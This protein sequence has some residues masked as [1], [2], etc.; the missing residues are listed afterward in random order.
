MQGVGGGGFE[1]DLGKSVDLEAFSDERLSG[2]AEGKP[3]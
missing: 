3:L 1:I 2:I